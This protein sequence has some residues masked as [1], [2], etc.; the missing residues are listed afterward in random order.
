MQQPLISILIPFKNTQKFLSECLDS[1]ITQTYTN[2]ELLI[3]DDNSTDKSYNLVEEYANSDKRI[4][5]FK[6]EGSGIIDALKLAFSKSKGDYITRMDSDDI[7]PTIKLETLLNNLKQ[8]GKNYVA[9]GLVSYFS[10]EGISDGYRK[11][12][13]WLNSLTTKG[14]NYSEIY[15]E[16]VIPSP[17]WMISRENLVAIDAFNPVRYPEDYDLTFRFYQANYKVIAC[18]KVLHQWRDYGTRASRTDANYA[19]NSFIDIKLHYFLKLD[20]NSSQPLVIWGAGN[21][22]KTIAKKLKAL[23]IPFH[24]ICDNP[25][26]IGKHIYDVEMKPFQYLETLEHFQCIVSV[27]NKEEQVIIRNYFFKLTKESMRDYFFFC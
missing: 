16:C 17:C 14:T 20:Y 23:N 10:A 27:A 24:W 19:E 13:D 12:E 8:H 1:L 25:K 15:K 22:G 7:M 6:N 18:D 21:K 9:T 3:I 26:K 11:Y 5:L 2:W 4:K